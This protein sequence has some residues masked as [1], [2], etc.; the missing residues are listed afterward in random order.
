MRPTPILILGDSPDTAGGLSRITRDIAGQLSRNPRFRVATLGRG[1]VG[2]RHLPFPQYCIRSLPG[3]D[4][5][6]ADLPKVWRDFAGKERGIV[7]T[8]WDPTRTLWLS[9]PDLLRET[10]PETAQFLSEGH[11]DLWG[12]VTLDATGPQDRLSA[13][14]AD[15]LRGY[16]RLLAY[17][18]WADGVI[19]RSLGDVE[20]ARRS[21]TWMPH[22]LDL[23]R[24]PLRDRDEA[25][26]RLYPFLHEG[27]KLVGAIGTNQP[28][29][30]WGLVASVC[31]QLVAKDRELKLWWHTDLLERHW[32]IPALLHDFGLAGVARVTMDLSQEELSWHYVASDLTLHPGLG[33]GF[34]YPI[35]E[36]LASGT[37]VLHGDYAGGAD[38]LRQCEHAEMLLSPVMYRLDGLHNQIRPVFDPIEWAKRAYTFLCIEEKAQDS[39][40]EALRASIAHL[41]W[42]GLWPMFKRWFEEG[43]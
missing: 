31:Q 43:L 8:I 2:S 39:D 13:M 1:A 17:T 16:H 23:A 27:Q 42:D 24:W 7:F 11:F 30:D 6:H 37:P 5:G 21:L 22:G 29:K 3:N 9:R 35:F 40:R 34:G 10:F 36:S 33:E 41:S 20:C 14:A 4:W 18:K 12:Y 28:R 25:K 15:S 38:V 19:R 32:S 26:A